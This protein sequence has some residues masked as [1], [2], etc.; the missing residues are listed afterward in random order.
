MADIDF[1]LESHGRTTSKRPSPPHEEQISRVEARLANLAIGGSG[2]SGGGSGGA[3]GGIPP[4]GASPASPA[5]SPSGSGG[6][7]RAGVGSP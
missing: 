2:G 1:N 3:G 7:C 4:Y 6:K 5:G